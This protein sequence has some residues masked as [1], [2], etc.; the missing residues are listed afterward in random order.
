[1]TFP[2]LLQLQLQ[3]LLLYVELT[4]EDENQNN[5]KPKLRAL[6]PRKDVRTP[7]QYLG[8]ISN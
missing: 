4:R 3:L 6:L 8:P 7:L 2:W 1:M 5:Q